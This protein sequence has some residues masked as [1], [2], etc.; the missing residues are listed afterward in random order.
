MNCTGKG[1]E[2]SL[3]VPLEGLACVE[4]VA[5]R[6]QVRAQAPTVNLTESW[7]LA[8]CQAVKSIVAV[9]HA[10]S[11]EHVLEWFIPMLNRLANGRDA[12]PGSVAVL[13]VSP[14]GIFWAILRR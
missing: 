14:E 7:G 9:V 5:V 10:L 12:A 13:R 6:E 3:L 11:H 8:S 1:F 2:Y 4:E